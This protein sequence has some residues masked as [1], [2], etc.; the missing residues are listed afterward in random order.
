MPNRQLTKDGSEVLYMLNR[1][2]EFA[3]EL[4]KRRLKGKVSNQIQD[5]IHRIINSHF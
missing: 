3:L 2:A 1:Y 4:L 5:D